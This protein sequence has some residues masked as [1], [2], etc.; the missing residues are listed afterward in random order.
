MDF[1]VP[2]P[3]GTAGY[4]D[5]AEYILFVSE[6]DAQRE[7]L[8]PDLDLGLLLRV[9]LFRIMGFADSQSASGN[10]EIDALRVEAVVRHDTAHEP[11]LLFRS[12]RLLPQLF[13]F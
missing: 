5:T 2:T 12:L 8:Q 13:Q 4:P 10:H 6:R 11:R 9:F 3:S 7:L 1:K